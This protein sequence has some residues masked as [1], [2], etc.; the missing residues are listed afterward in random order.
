MKSPISTAFAAVALFFAGNG[1]AGATSY[2]FTGAVNANWFNV[3]NWTPQGLPGP[4]DTVTISNSVTLTNAVTVGTFNLATGTFNTSTNGLTI[5]QGGTWVGGVLN[6]LVTN[7]SPSTTPFTLNSTNGN[8][9]LPNTTFV[10]NGNVL[11]L[12][13]T[14]RGNG[15]TV[16]SNN[17]YW[18][19][20][21]T[22]GVMNNAYGGT[23]LFDN[24]I[25]GELEV[26]PTNGTVTFNNIALNNYGSTA[27]ATVDVSVGILQLSGGGTLTGTLTV[28]SGASL[29]LTQGSFFAGNNF[30]FAVAGAASLTG[31]SLVLSNNVSPN[32]SLAGGTVT[33]GPAFQSSGAI[34]NLTLSGSTLAGTNTLLGTLNWQAG[35]IAGAFTINST[36]LLN[37]GGSGQV[38][39]QGALTNSG[40]ILWNGS[41]NWQIY[42]DGGA[43]NGLI[44]NLPSG[45]ILAQ[46]NNSLTSAGNPWFDNAGTFTKSLSTGTTS[47]SVPFTNTG[48]V[49]VLSGALTFGNGNFGG[50]FQTANGT[51]LTFNNG[52][53]LAGAF[54]AAYD[55]SINFAGGTFSET[56]GVTFSGTGA[57]QMTGG[58]LTLLNGVPPNLALNS[59]TVSLSPNFEGGVITNLTMTGETLA[60]SN[61]VTGV[62]NLDGTT[63]GPLVI[64]S[65]GVVNWSGGT[66]SGGLVISNGG[67]LNL[68]GSNGF[69]AL[70]S[71]ATNA[72]IVN[73]IGGGFGL[74]YGNSFANLAAAQ[75]NIECDQTMQYYYGTEIFNNAGLVQKMGTTGNTYLEPIFNNTGSVVVQ[76]GTLIFNGYDANASL[77]GAFLAETGATINFSGGGDLSGNFT[78]AT[79]ANINLTGGV[80]TPAPTLNFNGAG[81]NQLTGGT[82]TLT[83]AFIPNLQMNGGTAL[84]APSF[85]GGF[86]TNLTFNG[87]SI[88]GTNIVTGVLNLFGNVSGPLTILSNATLNLSGNIDSLVTLNPGATLNWSNGVLTANLPLTI[89]TNA[90]LNIVGPGT[91]YVEGPLTNAGTLNWSNGI[92]DIVNYY[93]YGDVGIYNLPGAVFNILGNNSDNDSGLL[94]NAGL[95]LKYPGTGLTE[96]DWTVNNTGTIDVRSG[97]FYIGGSV[98]SSNLPGTWLVEAG[99]TLT[100]DGGGYLTGAFTA[101]AGAT[102]NFDGGTFTNTTTTLLDGP[103]VYNLNGATYNVL[104]TIPPNL[105]LLSGSIDPGPDFQGGSIS[106]LTLNGISIAGSNVVSGALNINGDILGALTIA[107]GGNVTVNG[108]IAAPVLIQSGG[109]LNWNGIYLEDPINIAVGGTLNLSPT[110]YAYIESPITNFG[111]INWRGGEIY[112]DDYYYYAGGLF[113]LAGAQ[114]NFL[115]DQTIYGYYGDYLVNAGTIRK[116]ASTGISQINLLVTNTGVIDAESG[117]IQFTNSNTSYYANSFVQSG[118]TWDIGINSATNYGVIAFSTGTAPTLPAAL[119]V[120]LNNGYIL[121]PGNNFPIVDYLSGTLTGAIGVTN[122]P[123]VGASWSL[124]QS[125][126]NLTLSVA[127]LSVP[128]VTLTSPAN[129]AYL[130]APSSISLAAT[131]NSTNGYAI[132]SVQFFNGNTLLAQVSASPYAYSWNSVAP[133]TYTLTAVATDAHGGINAS[134][135]VNINVV[136]TGP[137]TTNYVWTGAISADWFIAGNWTPNGVPG[138]LDNVLVT[139]AS[140]AIFNPALNKNAVVNNL[141]LSGGGI[142]GPGTLTA[143][144]LFAWTAGAISNTVFIP[145]NATLLLQ[146]AGNLSLSG[147]TIINMGQVEWLSGN[148]SANGATV[149]TNFGTWLAQSNN[150]CNLGGTTPAGIFVNNGILRRANSTGS[151][152][153]YEGTFTN[154]GLVDC[155]SGSFYFEDLAAITG[156]Y[157]AVTGAII[158][159]EANCSLAAPPVIT[160]QGTVEFYNGNLTLLHDWPTGLSLAGGSITLGPGFQNAGAITNLTLS[161]ATLLGTNTVTGTFN[162]ASGDLSTGILTVEPN[163]LLTFGGASGSVYLVGLNLVNNGEVIWQNGYIGGNTASTVT[164]N[165]LWLNVVG[166]ELYGFTF[167]NNGSFR[168]TGAGTSYLYVPSFVN[169][170][171][172][173]AEA[174]TITLNAGGSFAGNFN[175]AAGA[176]INFGGGTNVLFSLPNFTGLGTFLF[177]GGT[178][179]MNN[180]IDPALQL[181][182]GSIILGPAFQNNGSISSLTLQGATLT[183]TNTVTGSLTVLSGSL[184]GALTINSNASM[185]LSSGS[186]NLNSGAF[187]NFGSVFCTG[188]SEFY[189]S[190]YGA[191]YFVN[192][193]LWL[194]QGTFVFSADYAANAALFINNG[195]Y[196]QQGSGSYAYFEGIAVN[197]TNLFDIQGGYIYLEYG[198]VLGG[199]Y[200][201]ATGASLYLDG[202]TFTSGLPVPDFTGSG[203]SQLYGG[204]LLL[205]NDQIPSLPL[206]GGTVEIGPSFQRLGTITNLTLTGATLAGTNFVSGTLNLGSYSEFTGV[207]TIL[208][209]GLLN[210]S[211]SNYKELL[212]S[213]LVNQGVV[214]WTGGEIICGQYTVISNT[215]LWLVETDNTFENQYYY[216]AYSNLF[217]N[218]GT[219]TKTTTTGSTVFEGISFQNAGTLDVESGLVNLA[220]NNLNSYAQTGATLA[221]GI[222]APSAAGQLNLPTNFNFDGTLRVN[223]LH[224]YTP[225]LG[226]LISIINYGSASNA[227]A[228]L[229]LP[230]VSS[231]NAWD[232]EY[233]P[234]GINLRVVSGVTNGPTYSIS[235]VVNN[236][237]GNPISGVAVYASDFGSTNLIVNG[238]FEIPSNNGA[239]YTTYNPG[240]TNIPG[241]SVIVNTIDLGSASQFGSGSEDGLQF[242]DPTGSSGTNGG[243]TQTFPTVPGTTYELVFYHGGTSHYSVNNVLGVTIAGNYYTFNETDGNGANFDWH[244]VQ[245]PFTATA[246]ATTVTFLGLLNFDANDNW[247]DNVQVTAPGLGTAPQAVTD[248]S[249]HYQISVPNGTFQVGVGGLAVA[250]YNPVSTVNVAVN[251][252]N[253]TANFTANPASSGQ[254]FTIA[255]AVTPPGLGTATGG[256]TGFAAGATVTVVATQLPNA[257]P[258]FFAGW[259]ENGVLESTNLSYAFPAVRSRNLVANFSLPGL[260]VVV[261]NNPPTDGIVS[262]AGVYAY[263]STSVLTAFPYTGYKFVNWTENG[264]V[265]GTSPTLNTLVLT[266]HSFIANY[267]DANPTHVVTTATSPAGLGP[268]AGAGT[269]SDGQTA[270]ITAPAALTNNSQLYL[271]QGFT[272]NGTAVSSAPSFSKSFSTFDPSALEY[273]AV[274]RAYPLQPQIIGISDNYPNPVPATTGFLLTFQFD[275][276]MKTVPTPLVVLTNAAPGAV[277]PTVNSNG[278]W[279]STVFTDDTYQTP[280]ITFGNQMDGTVQVLVSRAQDIYGHTL[281]ATNV[282]NIIVHSTAPAA[283]VVVITNPTNGASFSTAGSF[284]INATATSTNVIREVDFYANGALLS[285]STASPYSWIVNGLTEG[286][287]T[288]T[289]VA[290]DQ[291]GLTGTSGPLHVT[292]NAPGETLIDF[293]ALN[294]SAGALTGATLN[295]YLAGFGVVASNVTPAAAILAAEDDA[296]FLGGNSVVASSGNNFLAEVG[297]SGAVSYTLGFSQS[298]ASVSWVRPRLLAGTTGASLPTWRAYAFNAAGQQIGSVGES[299]TASYTD[300]PA[301]NFTLLGPG[302][303][304][305]RFDGNNGGAS[306]LSTL[307]LDDLLLSTVAVN[308]TLTVALSHGVGTV[309]TSP[310]TIVLRAAVNDSLA[311]VTNVQFYEGANLLGSAVPS[312][313][314]AVLTLSSV[315][316]GNYTFTAVASDSNGAAVTSSGLPVAVSVGAGVGV[317][318]F[319]S[320]DTS[321]GSVGGTVLSNYLYGFG[322]VASSVTVGTALDAVSGGLVTGS[323][324]GVASSP[325]NYFTQEG[326]NQPVSF[327][328]RFISPLADF[329]LTR[330]GLAAGVGGVTHPQW[331]ATAYDASGLELGAVGEGLIVS[332]TNVPARSFVLGGVS[333]DGIASVQFNSDSKKTAA[334]SAALLDDLIL[335]TNT[336]LVTLPL[337]V[338]MLSPQNGASSFVAPANITL[339]A[340]V[341]DSLSA[342]YSVNFYAGPNLIGSVSNAPYNL[343]WTNVLAG[344]YALRAEAVDASGA[345]AFSSPV[346]IIVQAGGNSIVADFDSITATAGPVSGATLSNYLDGFGMIVTDLSA[347][348]QLAAENQALLAGG[349]VVAASSPPNVLTQIGSS[350]PVSYTVNFSPWLQH[351]ALTRPELLPAPYVSQPAWTMTAYDAAGAVLAQTGEG[352]IGSYT[353]VG[354]RGFSVNGGGAGI[355]SVQIA[356]AGNGLTTFNGM[357]A[358]DFVLTGAGAVFPPA[359]AITNPA[360]GATLTGPA[361]LTIA[362]AAVAQSGGVTVSFYVNNVLIGAPVT[363]SPYQVEWTNSG[364]GGYALTA[365]ASNQISGGLVRTSA[366][367]SITVLPPAYQFGIV[368]QPAPLTNDIGSSATFS[369]IISGTNAVTYQ[370]NKNS[371]PLSGQIAP[372]LTVFPVGTGDAGTYTVTITPTDSAIPPI[373]SIGAVLTIAQPPVF[374]VPPLSLTVA[375]GASVNLTNQVQG[376]GPFNWQWLLNG[377]PISGETQ[378]NFAVAAVQPLNSGN[379]QV[380]CA[381]AVASVPSSSAILTVQA[382][383]GI[384]ESANTFAGRI[385]INPLLGPVM[386]N[387]VGA[388]TEPNDP[389]AIAGKPVGNLIWY[390]WTASFT[391]VISLTTL[392]SDFDTLLGV[393][394]GASLA[395]LVPVAQDDDSGGFFTS[396]VTFNVTAGTTYQIAVGGYKG[397]EGNVILGMPSGT[398]YRV[399]N[400]ATGNTVPVITAQP[401]NQLVLAGA[402]V[403]NSVTAGGTGPLTY[404]WYFQGGPI[405]GATNSSLVITNFQSGAVGLY[406]VLVVNAVGSV[407]SGVASVQIANG[408]TT[409]AQDKFG[410]AVDLVA[411]SNTPSEAIHEPT[412][413]GDTRGF[414]V[415]QTFSTVAATKETGEPNHCGQSGGASQW[416]IYTAPAG[417]TLNVSTAGSTFNTILAIYTVPGNIVATNF[418]SLVAQGCGFTT[419]YQTQGQPDVVIPNVVSGT[420]FYVAVDGYGGASGKAQLQIGLGVPPT[421]LVM[422]VSRQVTAG[423]NTTFSVSAI[424]STNLYYQWQLNGVPVP[425][426]TNASYTASQAG[427]YTVVVSNAVG[428]VTS[429]PAATLSLQYA[430][431]ITA[432][433]TNVAV[434]EGKK[435]GF[436]VTA[437]GVNTKTN[438]FHYQWYQGG[439]AVAGA[440]ASNL[441][442]AAAQWTNHGSYTVVVSNSY[443]MATS[444]PPA[445]LTLLDPA[446]PVAAITTPSVNN[447]FTL[448]SSILIAGTAS[449][450]VGVAEVQVEV[451]H[452]GFQTASGTSK[453]SLNVTLAPGTNVISAQTVSLA[454]NVGPVVQRNIIYE[455]GKSL[456]LITNG[457]GKI[458]SPDGAVNNAVLIVS[459]RYNVTAANISGSGYLFSN[460]VSGSNLGALTNASAT[461]A[462][463]FLMQTNLILQANFVTNPFPAAA[464]IYNG[465]FSPASGVTEAS[466]GFLHATLQ[467]NG[468]GAYSAVLLLAGQSNSFNGAF[469]VTGNSQTNLTLPGKNVVNVQL[470]LPLYPANNQMTGTISSATAG[471]TS[472]LQSWR[473]VFNATTAPATNYAGQFTFFLPPAVNAPA[474]SPDGYSFAVVTNSLA[475]VA[476][477]VGTLAD[478]TPIS[479]SVG[480]GPDGTLPLYQS[481]YKGAGSLQG[482]IIFTNQPPHALSGQLTWIKQPVA[483]T[484][485]PLGFTNESSNILGSFYTN[486]TTGGNPALDP[487]AGLLT[488]SN[489]NLSSPLIYKVGLGANN[490]LTNLGGADTSTN[491]VAIQINP[492]TGQVTVTFRATGAKTNTVAQGAILQNQTNALGAFQGA[493]Q[494][495]SLIVK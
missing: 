342:S 265:A 420:R 318:N 396:L 177:S 31:G 358:D 157:N 162:C 309:L 46:C 183:G 176:T 322:V 460:W 155:Q 373:T 348:T 211:G 487:P 234:T 436:A 240:A 238:S 117:T 476:N 269:Y 494:S 273:F 232:V 206:A 129:N 282:T 110:N 301:A 112:L 307:P 207:L 245:I 445:V 419:N 438:P 145:T 304:S 9:D 158:Y 312:S 118:G 415:S 433:P 412:G 52:G 139:N 288:L 167:V 406:Y 55:A 435:A 294:A 390:T 305:V 469:D 24:N 169:N 392:G 54:S 7:N 387:T 170:G 289:A 281:S 2:I 339:S 430:P 13:G 49:N 75:F 296:V 127:N 391:G 61:L 389:P 21:A 19:A 17:V 385:S 422:P 411:A 196:R 163:A 236:S 104:F 191:V 241:W 152:I 317:I 298:Y 108:Y 193:G 334:F 215:G 375:M 93:Y 250:G 133:G 475:G 251:N 486:A 377:T 367:V 427:A 165:S 480:L 246:T 464:G 72:G 34:T 180:D 181:T 88:G 286:S 268:V 220:A 344:N 259:T 159:L 283:P 331:T 97:A 350:G 306:A 23:P 424:G 386:G 12:A 203:S 275:R 308:T 429:A 485:Y 198:G 355:A 356:S 164:N 423:S 173:D 478:G 320:L 399:L 210:L 32:L 109:T 470:R 192:N 319:D 228:N 366:V 378:S 239:N 338:S 453:W 258:Y 212:G 35:T 443:G 345:A 60:G 365:V 43:N 230:A 174:G 136:T 3:T 295:N 128:V 439:V 402:R 224:G 202:G 458:T 130:V 357:V 405:N 332:A 299:A 132:A 417:G 184:T 398:G 383:N 337:T 380:V 14:I 189:S 381:N 242:F 457:V 254:Y 349:G 123:A 421:L 107:A 351:F 113:N 114:F 66:I 440:T 489:G 287:Y 324:G 229:D 225:S 493:T 370:W 122:L 204:T 101:E 354:A 62:L 56:S 86:I 330:V 45:V 311:I 74:L 262:G 327:I 272:L 463:S 185:T 483:K 343:A 291:S 121:S 226:D 407:Q 96:V 116:S 142:G 256:G 314:V 227:F 50:A 237:Q 218:N 39:L 425:Q 81:T 276:S 374:L 30:T 394:T 336:G 401:T 290:I 98:Q 100:L 172:V 292:V 280:G 148:I 33:L 26:N 452:N 432:E 255:T 115:N 414:S 235:G 418:S 326:L 462:L 442:F 477:L 84:L 223:A 195:V 473:A 479:Q 213:N 372:T 325:P 151:T 44:N 6:G 455:V 59:G 316:A 468:T 361:P 143:T 140:T 395:Q 150:S 27:T 482:W 465:L 363:S 105:N 82:L 76:S 266:N 141:T 352:A 58:N 243:L 4:S 253:Q 90:I 449:D 369:V 41:G 451:N 321:A 388:G 490:V 168:Q 190:S 70:A 156:A 28:E 362:A 69:M 252:A 300:I 491:N 188:N 57:M 248:A 484:L 29:N 95:V 144:N 36:G 187:T 178:L 222:S 182:G 359:V 197:N 179:V 441:T 437:V 87:P 379:Y 278:L 360:S 149:I 64:A 214:D 335:Y 233:G 376:V 347:G 48:T 302:I 263:N 274:Y 444:T 1:L 285:A 8:L 471:W 103:G 11:W 368:S 341:G 303:A 315:A 313:G 397:A 160:G 67:V 454:G 5:L 257:L 37:L 78:A 219:F 85:Q 63:A 22:N 284:T 102:L 393:Y 400:A 323:G 260:G 77:G 271:F 65:S 217:V 111:T 410:D 384:L 428:V 47:V 333:G 474:R 16:I 329:G 147:A 38:T 137:Q 201:V 25:G 119:N 166:S 293:E 73:W 409:S 466:S 277:Q 53:V 340:G 161:G 92:L 461:P 310:G 79:G 492:A 199:T 279:T 51:Q 205:Q 40:E 153:F 408:S 434:A 261:S 450:K 209:N 249:G 364:A 154:N 94:D 10:N 426:A 20:Q 495:G 231:G 221:F 270:I 448:N 413:G 80:F 353:P 264:T 18:Q 106:G 267:A 83:N 15:S 481:L 175:T 146:S 89:P 138:V 200:N 346:N 208:T 446:S 416:Y 125:T 171:I 244:R 68:T 488:L 431:G 467:A 404:Q 71:S 126:T 135:P 42:N 134:A 447:F 216:G 194:N 124:N 371:S 131:A 382:G 247:V 91:V 459:N 186:F 99:A 456:T 328:L 297:A 403:T 120:Q 472:T